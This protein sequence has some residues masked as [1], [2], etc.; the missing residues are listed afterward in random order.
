MSRLTIM[1]SSWMQYAHTNVCLFQI[2]R[3]LQ[4][5]KSFYCSKEKDTSAS[6]FIYVYIYMLKDLGIILYVTHSCQ[7]LL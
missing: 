2:R 3:G 4:L 1:T 5:E 7:T 6:L